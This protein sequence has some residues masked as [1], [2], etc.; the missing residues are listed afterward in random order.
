MK[1][2]IRRIIISLL[3]SGSVILLFVLFVPRTYDVPH[4][5]ELKETLYWNLPT[6][7][8]IAYTFIPSKGI[9]KP[10]PIIFLQ[11][12]PGGFYTEKTI[13]IFKV[14]SEK[15]FDVYLYDQIG[16]GHS[17]RLENISEYTADRHKRDLEEIV[18]I[19]GSTKVTLI[20]QSWG[21]I[22]ATL[23]IADN[24]SKVERVIF[25]GPGP[26]QPMNMELANLLPPDSL[27][28]RKPDFSNA[29]A[30][31][32]VQNLRT[33]LISKWALLTGKRLASDSEAD[34]F[35]TLLNSKLG[36]STV[37]DTSLDLS[38]EGGGGFYVQVM[39]I[40]SLSQIKDPR[41]EFRKS[42]IP[43]LVM[44]GQCDNQKWGYTN[45]YLQ[46]FQNHKLVIIPNAGHSISVEQP[47][48]YLKTICDFLLN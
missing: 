7:S 1:I 9:R 34:D 6:G 30:N 47:V 17:A 16:G 41:P 43:V 2:T 42:K 25:T 36:K 14:F 4:I 28:L 40:Q 33:R 26:I 48:L 21:A 27:H 15:G 22:L 5:K 44:K 31:K 38:N 13:N 11:G 39:T 3:S 10:Y 37:C 29:Q 24:P 12:G 46:L 23:F 32:S 35:Q 8:R 20:A 18:K 45:E 19:I